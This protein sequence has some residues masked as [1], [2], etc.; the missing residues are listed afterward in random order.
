M[1]RVIDLYEVED[2]EIIMLYAASLPHHNSRSKICSQPYEMRPRNQR[3]KPSMIAYSHTRSVILLNL[4]TRKWLCRIA[5][6]YR[7]M[8]WELSTAEE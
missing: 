5:Q 2:S 3:M 8:V 6:L 7:R 4:R 1:F